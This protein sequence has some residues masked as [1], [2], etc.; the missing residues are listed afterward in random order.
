MGTKIETDINFGEEYRD[1]VTGFTGKA[2]GIVK[3]Q[4]GCIRI[5]LQ[6]PI[7]KDGKVPETQ[8]LDEESIESIKPIEKKT[9]GPMPAPKRRPDP[10]A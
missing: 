7:D 1:T 4:F 10:T 8:W 3:H 9:G 2:T 6:P 5:L